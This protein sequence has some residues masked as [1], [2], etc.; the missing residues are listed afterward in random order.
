MTR[1]LSMSQSG[2]TAVSVHIWGYYTCALAA[3]ASFD[4]IAI[5]FVR[6]FHAEMIAGSSETKITTAII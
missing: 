4:Q 3:L 5:F 6:A 1:R 2:A